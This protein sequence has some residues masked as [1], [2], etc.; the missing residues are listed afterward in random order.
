MNKYFLII[1][2]FIITFPIFAR[3]VTITVTDVEIDLPL[4]GAVIHSWDEKSFICDTEGKAVIT[5]PDD[6]QV[7]VYATYPGY[8]TGRII[9]PVTGEYF[10]IDLHLSKVMYAREL[11]VEG[12]RPGSNESRTG[13][14]IA[15]GEK[16][17]AQ[18]GEIGIIEDVMSTI[19]LLPGVNYSGFFNAMPSIR[20]GHPGD[21]IAALDGFYINNP[22]HWGGGYSI[23]DPRMVQS[24]KLS[25]GV[26]SSRYGN[27]ISGLLEISSKKPSVTEIEFDYGANIS[28]ANLSFSFPIKGKGGILLLGRIT[29]YDPFIALAKQISK[30]MPILEPVNSINKAPFIRAGA[31]NGNYRFTGSL[32][33]AATAFWGMD[34]VGVKYQNS[35]RT[36]GLESDSEME[37]D[38]T[39]YQGFLT[40]RLSW[41][42]RDDMLLKFSAGTGY[43]DVKIDGK[44]SYNIHNKEFSQNFRDN[45]PILTYFIDDNYQFKQD[46]LIKQSEFTYNLQG[47]IDYDWEISEHF[48]A[49]AGLQEMFNNYRSSGEQQMLFDRRFDSLGASD[50]E[51]IISTFH[52]PSEAINYLR[53]GLPASYS[54][55]S[56]NRLFSTSAYILGEYSSTGNRFQTELGLRIDH[57]L[58]LGDGFTLK[59]DPV[60]NPRINFDFNILKNYSLI[61]SLDISAGTGLFSSV[62]SAVFIAEEK[63]NIDYMKPNRSWTSILGIK[64]EFPQKVSFTIEGYYKYVFNRMYI[65]IRIGID[66][67]DVNPSFDGIGKVWGVDLMLQ[68]KE[69]SYFD[70]WLTYSWNWAKYRD[71]GGRYGAMGI[72]GGNSGD[73]WYFPSYHRFHNLNLIINIK[74]VQSINIYVR[75][76]LA[77]GVLLSKRVGDGPVSYPLLIYDKDNPSNSY[78]IEK[79]YWPSVSDESNRTT[80]SLPMDVKF[81]I[82]GT[83]KKKNRKYEVYVAVENVLSLLYTSQGNTSFNSY[84]GQVDTGSN[85]A[86]YDIPIPIPSFGFKMNF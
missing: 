38:F 16:E 4:E 17:I 27:T 53:V 21:M 78:F 50:Q 2:I 7:S 85:S 45:F 5:V 79:Y 71:P 37:F 14:S 68:R 10:S 72:S 24:A 3:N 26:F 60:F 36:S 83:T 9:I 18:T 51:K 22:Y 6:R 1:Y 19:K 44:M 39:N 40:S 80:P 48:I 67:I 64:L 62:N 34:G 49:A 82:F 30:I 81:T 58:L 56:S 47:R 75:F 13:R 84:T 15:V 61:R 76:G 73:D 29:Y 20:G 31:I 70:G 54:P 11:V 28:A 8:D 41:N 77:S 63:Y 74:P 25:H 52:L 43:E 86:R 46:A 55:D 66:D 57:F 32:E 12:S 69:S 59:S 65:P 35:N 33:F 42:P 23:F